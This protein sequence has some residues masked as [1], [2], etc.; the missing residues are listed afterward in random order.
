MRNHTQPTSINVDGDTP[1][2]QQIFNT[3]QKLQH[4]NEQIR[5]QTKELQVEREHQR[6]EAHTEQE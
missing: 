4:S 6:E 3:M 1:T 5:K 2:L